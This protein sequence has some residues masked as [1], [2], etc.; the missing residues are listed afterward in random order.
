V[1]P[2]SFLNSTILFSFSLYYTHWK[3]IDNQKQTNQKKTKEK[4]RKKESMCGCTSGM[5]QLPNPNYVIPKRNTRA[6]TAA[7]AAAPRQRM[8]Q[9]AERR[10][11]QM[12]A[13]RRRQLR[14]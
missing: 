5:W 12:I 11:R 14:K 6:A 2:F 8:I 13:I 9:S 10:R 4:E 3:N 7:T 1:N